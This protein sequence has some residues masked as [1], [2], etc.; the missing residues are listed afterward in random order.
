MRHNI[1]KR[2]K[3]V[4]NNLSGWDNA[5]ADATKGI[6][7]LK[8]ALSHAKEMKAAGEPWPGTQPDSQT[9]ESCHGI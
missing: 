1:S 9:T 2:D 7:R 4:K 5:I 3:N 8:A 6:A